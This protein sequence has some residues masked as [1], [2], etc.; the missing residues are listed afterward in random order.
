MQLILALSCVLEDAI[1]TAISVHVIICM[2]VQ[3][4]PKCPQQIES[5]IDAAVSYLKG[6]V[7]LSFHH[8]HGQP[9][10]IT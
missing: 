10:C 4:T 6:S 7:S 1:F 3:D 2:R 8:I 5:I 9:E